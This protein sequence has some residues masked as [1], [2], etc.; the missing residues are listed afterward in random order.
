MFYY[1]FDWEEVLI[2][3][4]CCAPA[5]VIGHVICPLLQVGST[6]ANSAYSTSLKKEKKTLSENNCWFIA[7]IHSEFYFWK[8]QEGKNEGKK[9]K[10]KKMCRKV[11]VDW[12]EEEKARL[13]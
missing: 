10:N 8:M 6:C 7:K 9:E 12:V 2:S 11:W 4:L 1:Y 5:I 13:H 3:E